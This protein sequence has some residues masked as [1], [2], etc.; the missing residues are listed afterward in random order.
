MKKHKLIYLAGPYSHKSRRVRVLREYA[1]AECAV[2]LLKNQQHVY[3]PIVET[4]A[5]AS[6]G[7]LTDT[8]W[9][10]WRNHDLVLLGR[11]DNMYILTIGGWKESIGVRGEV[12]FA[13]KHKKGIYFVTVDGTVSKKLSKTKLLKYFNV[14]TEGEL[15]D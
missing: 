6:R 4:T 10:F 2:R 12:K 5:L 3:S 1:H 9:K 8:D 13:L 7:G 14:K 11:C 15:N